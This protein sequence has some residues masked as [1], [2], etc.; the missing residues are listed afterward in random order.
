MC[1]VDSS[2]RMG[3][4]IIFDWLIELDL[5]LWSFMGLTSL[6]SSERLQ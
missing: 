6:F 4:Q 2:R 1:M 5:L 3:N